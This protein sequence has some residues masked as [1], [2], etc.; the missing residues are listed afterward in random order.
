MGECPSDKQVN[1]KNGIKHDNRKENLELVSPKE[2]TAH[3]LL[4]G[5]RVM[6]KGENCHASILKDDEVKLMYEYFRHGFSNEEV[7]E[8]YNIEWKHASLIRNGKRWKHLFSTYGYSIPSSSKVV[9]T[10][11]SQISEALLLIDAGLTNKD[12]SLATGIE[13]STVSRIRSGTIF[14]SKLSRLKPEY[15]SIT[16]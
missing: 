11:D 9:V 10:T 12:I 16:Q 8:I 14:T 3:A 13:P 2:N 6:P 7:A 5:L 4:T 15:F 1:H